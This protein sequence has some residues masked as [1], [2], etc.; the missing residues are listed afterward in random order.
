[1]VL[2]TSL[3]A[4]KCPKQY[5]GQTGRVFVKRMMEHLNYIYHKKEATGAHFTSQNHDHNDCRMQIIEK[6]IPNSVHYRLER[7]EYW[8]KT[9]GTKIPNGLNKRD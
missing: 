8:I 7:E 4:K 1:M 9:L 3:V 6:V 5:A 2:F